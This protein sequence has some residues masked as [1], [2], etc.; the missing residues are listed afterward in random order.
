MKTKSVLVFALLAICAIAGCHGYGHLYPIQGPLSALTPPPVFTAK[1]TGAFNS[2]NIS[3]VLADGEVF[4]GPWKALS[5]KAREQ[6]ANAGAPEQ[7]N[8]ASAWD[9]VYGQG[10]YTAHVLGTHLFATATLTGN[11]GTTLQMEMYRQ[12]HGADTSAP[13]DIKGVAKDSKGN[14]YK[15]VY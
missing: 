4:A 10:F 2:G 14:I 7:V 11:R 13:V 12:E 15:L 8:L 3:V 5:V 1:I 9:T 6:K